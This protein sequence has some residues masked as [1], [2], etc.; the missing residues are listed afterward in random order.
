MIIISFRINLELVI[1]LTHL[2]VPSC[3]DVYHLRYIDNKIRF[4]T[5]IVNDV[6]AYIE[7]VRIIHILHWSTF[8]KKRILKRYMK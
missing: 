5:A 6:D 3:D 2:R 7:T 8:S 4:F 1:F